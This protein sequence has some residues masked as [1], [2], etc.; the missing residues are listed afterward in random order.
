LGEHIQL[1]YETGWVFADSPNGV[2]SGLDNSL[3]G[4]KWRFLD[5]E[6]TGISMSVYPQLQVENNT[7][8]ASRGIVDLGP[9]LFLPIELSRDFGR[10]RLV[11]E[12]GYQYFRAQD[13]EWIVGIL[14]A[15]QASDDLEVMAELRSF[16]EKF[17]N[18]A[19]VVVNIGLRQRLSERFKLLASVGTGLGNGP[20]ATS[21]V[22]Y[23]G[24][25][26]M[27]GHEQKDARSSATSARQFAER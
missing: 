26:L 27:L 21:F 16:S 24:V 23:L 10:F 13:N 5:E 25:Q 15:F 4:L 1:K 8:S 17:L 22:A 2:K 18:R 3:L 20:Q 11:G 19:D 7:S 12:V 14:G 6:H 9:N